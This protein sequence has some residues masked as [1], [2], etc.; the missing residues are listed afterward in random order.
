VECDGPARAARAVERALRR[1]LLLLPSGDDG[2]VLS[3]T[4]PLTIE[5]EVLLAALEELCACLA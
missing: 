1:G 4:P 5:R 3:V 2:R